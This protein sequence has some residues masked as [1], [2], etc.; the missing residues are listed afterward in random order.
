MTIVRAVQSRIQSSSRSLALGLASA[1]LCAAASAATLMQEAGTAQSGAGKPAGASSEPAAI[2][3]AKVLLEIRESAVLLAPSPTLSPTFGMVTG[4]SGDRVVVTGPENLR[5]G[6]AAGQVATFTMG[7]TGQWTPIAEMQSIADCRPGDLINGRVA[8]A[9]SVLCLTHERRDGSNSLVNVLEASPTAASG[10][11]ASGAPLAPPSGSSEPAFGSAIA[12]DGTVIAVS[13]V[14]QR[15]LGEKARNVSASPKVFLFRSGPSG[16]TG[17]GYLQRDVAKDPKFFGASLAMVPG[18][19]VVGCP[20]AIQP[21]PKQPLVQ[22]GDSVVCIWRESGGQWNL[23][24]E[25][26]PPPGSRG[27]A[28]GQTV[29]ATSDTV[30][31]RSGYVSEPGADV[32]VYRKG[33]SG[34]AYDGALA[35]HGSA[36]P[37]AA[38]G[39]AF[40]IGEDFIA[41][42]DPSADSAFGKGVVAVFVRGP[43]GWEERARLVPSV[44]TMSARWGVAIRADG[45]RV[46]VGHPASEREGI[47]PGGGILFTV[48]PVASM[49]PVPASQSETAASDVPL[50]APSPGKGS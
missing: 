33:A 38:F 5:V 6:G 16:W 22:G 9:G 26:A 23:E 31:V 37:G 25:L 49:P 18:M 2:A 41:L 19:L 29:A 43:Q 11:I 50:G 36:K 39:A 21:A 35:L 28:F 13:C 45:R 44:K 42:G 47:A 32:F 30:V 17:L 34:W 40:A 20:K 46:L 15:V 8:F 14:D 27:L 1:A 7:L 12:T 24:A 10:W 4:M 48:P 3:Q